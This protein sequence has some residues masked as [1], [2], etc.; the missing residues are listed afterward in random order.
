MT[1]STQTNL[2]EELADEAG[3]SDDEVTSVLGLLI[4]GPGGGAIPTIT[5]ELDRSIH[6]AD[7]EPTTYEGDVKTAVSKLMSFNHVDE[8]AMVGSTVAE[9]NAKWDYKLMIQRKVFIINKLLEAVTIKGH[10]DEFNEDIE[11]LV[12]EDMERRLDLRRTA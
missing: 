1:C 6:E 9:Y 2:V 4:D 10:P 7:L 12:E 8:T 5:S 11:Q 3:L